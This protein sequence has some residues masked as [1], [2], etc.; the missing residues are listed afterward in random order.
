MEKDDDRLKDDPAYQI[1]WGVPSTGEHRW[2]AS[3]AIVIAMTLYFALPHRYTMG[4]TW[5]MPLL[6]L[7][8]LVPLTVSAP[9]RVAHEGQVQQILATVMIAIVNIANMASLVLL[10]RMLIFHGADI[11][12]SELIFSSASIWLTN[13]IVFSL[14]YWE[15]DRGGPNQRAHENHSGPDF[16]FP[17]MSVPGCSRLSWTPVYIDYLYLAFTN[18]TAFSPTDVMPLTPV[19]K[20]LMLAQSAISLITITLVAARAVNILS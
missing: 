19:A 10:V 1:A 9:R 15:I 7:A 20:I 4:P 2:P 5:L 6:E 3:L 11:N 18:A 13:V 16:L 14:W 12:G 8:V 17:Q